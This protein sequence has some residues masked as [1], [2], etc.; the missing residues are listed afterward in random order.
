[1]FFCHWPPCGPFRTVALFMAMDGLSGREGVLRSMILVLIGRSGSGKSAVAAGL[2]AR[3]GYSEAKSCTT[4]KRRDGEDT[5]AYTFL[6]GK[7][8]D[9]WIKEGR[10]AEWNAYGS[11]LYG[12]PKSELD[13]DGLIVCV[14]ST[15]GARDIKA[16]FP[17]A[18]V[19]HVEADM[20]ASVVRA[21]LREP[22]MDPGKMK[23]ISDR[24]IM[25]SGIYAHPQCDAVVAND[26]SRPVWEVAEEV[27]RLHAAFV[28][29]RLEQAAGEATP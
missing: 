16:A 15:E 23:R 19:V 9:G 1:M 5:G 3:C 11:G 18:F 13:R 10:F 12:T 4:R 8:F 17:D 29:G 27:A 22:D 6:T 25:D 2:A 21:V 7:E 20:K 28:E 24:A 26:G 14:M